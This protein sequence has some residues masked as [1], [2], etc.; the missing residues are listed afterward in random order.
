MRKDVKPCRAAGTRGWRIADLGEVAGSKG[1]KKSVL[2]S[3][4]VPPMLEHV[5]SFMSLYCH[6]EKAPGLEPWYSG[7]RGLRGFRELRAPRAP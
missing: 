7:L 1:N 3:S 2:S 5:P 6:Q 4:P